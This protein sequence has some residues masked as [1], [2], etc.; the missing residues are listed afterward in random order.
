MV[1]TT[2]DRWFTPA[3][4]ATPAA[5]RVRERLLRNDPAAWSATWHAIATFEARDRLGEIAVPA[6]VVAGECDA[7]TPLAAM[8]ALADALPNARLAVVP[9]A[10]HM[11][12]IESTDRF[13][14]AVGAFLATRRAPPVV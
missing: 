4:R 5:A 8:T 3:Y 14:E 12:Q 11:M 2:L 13:N 7:A 10:P 1:E 6:L 9:G